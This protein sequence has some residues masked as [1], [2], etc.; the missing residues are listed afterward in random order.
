M[1]IILTETLKKQASKS[2]LIAWAFYDWASSSY[3]SL[4]QTFVFAAYFT[5]SVADNEIKG[6]Y[7]WGLALGL[8]GIFIATGGPLLGAI[9]DHKS[10]RKTWMSFFCLLCFLSTALLWYIKPEPNYVSRALI[11]VSL[12]TIGSEFAFIFYNAMLPDLVP[13]EKIGTWSGIGWGM[14][15]VGGMICLIL[16]LLIFINQQ[17]SL[18]LLDEHSAEPVRATF[19]LTA[20]WY[21]LFALPLFLFTPDLKGKKESL[22]KAIQLGWDQLINSLRHIHHYRHLALFLA[23]RMIYTDGLTTLFLFGGVYAAGTFHMSVHNVLLF[24]IT[25]NISAGLGAFAFAFLDD[26]VGSK[27]VIIISLICLII[28]TTVLLIV[29]SLAIFWMFGI[30]LGVFVG[31]LQA[32]SRA[33]MAKVTPKDKQNQMFGLFAFSGKATGFVGPFFVSFITLWTASQR[34][35]ISIL[36]FFF[37]IGLLLILKVPSEENFEKL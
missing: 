34:W 30:L 1:V 3:S 19:L 36:L 32:S 16:S 5:H 18:W 26:Y 23:A 25:L 8:S 10:N 35:G 27:T 14:G 2:A 21:G 17:N 13:K 11:L 12:G 29:T 37:M 22:S 20:A 9:A 4:I 33:L 7:E 15:Y 28:T 6:S 24:A 31:P